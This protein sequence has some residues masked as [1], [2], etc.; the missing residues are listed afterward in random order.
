MPAASCWLRT[1][2]EDAVN[3]GLATAMS[4]FP[5]VLSL[6][7]G[8]LEESIRR[9]FN[10]ASSDVVAD[11]G[12]FAFAGVGAMGDPGGGACSVS[13]SDTARSYT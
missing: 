3:K 13:W 1:A 9:A 6:S 5:A 11:R 10:A 8:M 7:A 2:A 4:A 12:G